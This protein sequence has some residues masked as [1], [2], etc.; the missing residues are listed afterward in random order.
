MRQH[1]TLLSCGMRNKATKR[2]VAI[3]KKTMAQKRQAMGTGNKYLMSR[4]DGH[5]QPDLETNFKMKNRITEV[6]NKD[7]RKTVR[8]HL[9]QQNW[10]QNEPRGRQR[11]REEKTATKL[12]R[13]IKG[14]RRRQRPREADAADMKGDRAPRGDKQGTHMHQS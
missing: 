3:S 10:R 12:A 1:R 2:Q 4:K 11:T 5:Q 6:V 13:H 7:G 9:S 14:D 8:H